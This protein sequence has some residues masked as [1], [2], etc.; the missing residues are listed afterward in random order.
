METVLKYHSN[1]VKIEISKINNL[2]DLIN[3]IKVIL[4][5][6][7]NKEIDI[8]VLPDNTYLKQSNFQN[9]FL[10]KKKL[11]QGLSVIDVIDLEEKIKNIGINNPNI[12]INKIQEDSD[13]FDND[14][15]I[16]LDKHKLFKGQCSFCK[17]TFNSSKYSC[18]L[19]PNYYLCNK[20]EENHPHPMIKYKSDNL[21]DNISKI[22][23]IHSYT[24]KKDFQ[25]KVKEKLGVKKINQVQLRTN[26]SC[27]S[28]L[29][30]SNQERILNLIIKNN[31]KFTIPKNT[32]SIVIQNQYDLNIS[33]KDEVLFKDINPGIEVPINLN[34]KSNDK[35]LFETYHLKIEVMSNSLD[36]ISK[37]IELIIN[38]KND[39]EEDELNNKFKEFPS[40]ILLPK[41]KKKKLQYIIQEKLS[42]KTPQE[43][44]AIMEKFK[45]SI[46][47]AIIDLTN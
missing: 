3:Q 45:W 39:K 27:N 42:L 43:I 4:K 17:N 25:D 33:I 8:Y 37:P 30:G 22:I 15:S 31:N 36:I 2:N 34:I 26:L 41:E 6:D 12:P 47:Q 14:N 46:D 11:I 20:C 16:V 9:E 24:N 10:N 1:N 18:L 32:L 38:V 28:F 7:S 29:I 23:T 35:N 5:I 44:K 19:C 13:S 40:I 21:S